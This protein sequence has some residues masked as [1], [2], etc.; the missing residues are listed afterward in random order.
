VLTETLG[1]T[2]LVTIDRPAVRNAVNQSVWEGLGQALE[3]ADNTPTVRVV[4]VT[5]AGERA[6]CAGADLRAAAS[7]EFQ[8]DH[9][10][11]PD[12]EHWGFA[13]FVS[14]FISKPLIAAVNGDAI[15][16]G[17][18]IVL[19]CDLALAARN[20]RFAFPEVARGLVA[21]GG[22]AFRLP[23]LVPRV[24][25]MELLLTGGAI[26]ADR[27]LELG[28]LNAVV[29]PDELLPR[30][31]E[32]AERISANAPLAVQATKRIARGIIDAEAPDERIG[33]HVSAN[34][35]QQV[36]ASADA[37]EGPL[38]FVEHRAPRWQGR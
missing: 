16:G 19:A 24:L 1:H 5:G 12:Q 31:L 21:G 9:A 37:K 18:E 23:R 25:A 29:A 33:W 8:G 15:G 30:T 35:V 10:P 28:L 2:L 26:T 38:A 13:G 34:E 6:F 36:L 4:V 27:A 7:G 3:T 32:L 22:G 14:H 17:W 11:D 20:A